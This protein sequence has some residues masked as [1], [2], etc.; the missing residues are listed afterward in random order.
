MAEPGPLCIYEKRDPHIA[1]IQLNRPEKK[2]AIS[3]DLYWA[4]DE[5]WQ[6]AKADDD[7]WSIILTGT[8]DA[9]CVGGDLKENIAFARGEMT[10]PRSGPRG[11]LQPAPAANAQADH[12]RHQR[13]RGRRRLLAWR[14]PAISATACRRRSSAAPKC[15]GPI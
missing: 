3:R 5:C 13:L 9:F 11:V 7:V 14:C 15:A 2:N 6:K 12:R 4:L 8:A 10:G 1:I